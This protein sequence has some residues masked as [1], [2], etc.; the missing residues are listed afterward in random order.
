MFFTRTSFLSGWRNVVR[1]IKL[2]RER[3]AAWILPIRT[4]CMELQ[5]QQKFRTLSV[6]KRMR[7][8]E[9]VLL[10]G[11]P[12]LQGLCNCTTGVPRCAFTKSIQMNKLFPFFSLHLR[13]T[14]AFCPFL[15]PCWWIF[16]WALQQQRQ[17]VWALQ[18][19]LHSEKDPQGHVVPQ[20]LPT[21]RI[22]CFS[23]QCRLTGASR[24]L[25]QA[26]PLGFAPR[27]QWFNQVKNFHCIGFVRMFL[28]SCRAIA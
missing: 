11:L 5:A 20:A 1:I 22:L 16:Y 15:L 21:N 28:K 6:P 24:A 19:L 10:Q 8:Q 12:Q 14:S 4:D 2:H 27:L 9:E 17:P 26:L 3:G 23:G 13:G 18:S 7:I 25:S